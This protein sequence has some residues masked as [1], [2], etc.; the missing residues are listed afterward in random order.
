MGIYCCDRCM[1]KKIFILF[2]V[3]FFISCNSV[4]EKEI[5]TIENKVVDNAKRERYELI[6]VNVVRHG[7]DKPFSEL[8]VTK[9]MIAITG[10]VIETTES[11]KSKNKIKKRIVTMSQTNKMLDSDIEKNIAKL[12][13][14]N[15]ELV[16]GKIEEKDGIGD[17]WWWLLLLLL[18]LLLNKIR[19]KFYGKRG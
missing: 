11:Y 13:K 6:D 14:E 15:K 17:I 1:L 8:T 5:R 2:L 19:E 9:D 3:I 18:L 4:E 12:E 16:L 7:I 10:D